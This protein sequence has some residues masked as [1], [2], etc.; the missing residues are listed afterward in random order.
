MER[1]ADENAD[2]APT[3]FITSDDPEEIAAGITGYAEL[4]FDELILHAPGD[5]QARFLE[6]FSEDVLP[7]L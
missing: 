6:Q 4:G 5:D 1:L 3:R 7:L 2:R